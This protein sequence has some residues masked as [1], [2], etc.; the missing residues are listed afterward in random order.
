MSMLGIHEFFP[1]NKMMK[2]GGYFLCR[3]ESIFQEVCSNVLFLI[4]GY[5]SEQLNRTMLPAIL[6]NTPAGAAVDQLV[7]Y[8]QEI[9][10]AK[11]RMYDYG[12]FGNL[13]RY[14]SISPPS[15]DLNNVVA[16]VALHY[17]D[18]DWLAAVKDVDKLATKLPKMIGK[19]RVGHSKWNHLDFIW[20][21]EA[22]SYLYDRV[23]SLM[24]RYEE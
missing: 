7:H 8:A 24:E 6:Q 9:N 15:Y 17:S 20:G 22:K 18:N 14:G 3:D 1:S 12:M 23:I 21:M 16:P 10:S 11:F 4:C 19:F 13:G 5:N 2:K